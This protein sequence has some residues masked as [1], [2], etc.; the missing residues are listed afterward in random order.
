V[1]WGFLTD[2][3]DQRI[4]EIIHE[5]KRK[6][7]YKIMGFSKSWNNEVI[8][9]FYATCYFTTRND[10]KIMHWMTEG[11]SF[12]I[13]YTQF[14]SVVGFNDEDKK[15]IKIHA[16]TSMDKK[17][18]KFMYT[19]GQEWNYGRVNCML[20]FY[21]YL[22]RMFRKTIAPREGYQSNISNYGKDLLKYMNP[23]KPKFCVVD[24]I[25]EEIRIKSCSPQNSC[26]YAPYL[27][28]VI[29]F[30]TNY[31]FEYDPKHKPF[32]LK[33]DIKGPSLDDL[34]RN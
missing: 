1:D 15:R 27:M 18:M 2:L 12:G 19:P 6:N 33:N 5:C 24:Y 13:T 28:H 31:K 34:A 16:A 20:P 9:Q 32:H 26:G 17:D 11:I 14:A 10:E 30:I 25:W 22:H 3:Q 23:S 7:I 8:A 29:E 4:N 21:A